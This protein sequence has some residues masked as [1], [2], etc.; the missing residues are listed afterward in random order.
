MKQNMTYDE[1]AGVY[2]TEEMSLLVKLIEKQ[3]GAD[4]QKINLQGFSGFSY[5]NNCF[6][7]FWTGMP[8]IW[9][10]HVRKLQIMIIFIVD[11]SADDCHDRLISC[12]AYKMS[13]IVPK[14][15]KKRKKLSF[16]FPKA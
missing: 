10:Q 11:Q 9:F 15:K 13:Q 1:E 14:K 12:L 6:K 8:N 7:P 3:T 4:W 5:L 16:F 2:E